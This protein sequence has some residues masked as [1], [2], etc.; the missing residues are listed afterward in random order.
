MLQ[1]KES[2]REERRKRD[3][4]SVAKQ[5]AMKRQTIEY[6][7]EFKAKLKAQKLAMEKEQKEAL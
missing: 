2:I 3:E 7:Y 4:E 6:D 1:A 5:E